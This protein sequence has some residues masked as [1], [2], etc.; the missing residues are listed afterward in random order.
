MQFAKLGRSAM[1]TGVALL[2]LALLLGCGESRPYRPIPPDEPSA[3]W[4]S[5]ADGD[6]VAG[7][8]RLALDAKSGP[9]GL[10]LTVAG[11]TIDTVPGSRYLPRAWRGVW[12]SP[13]VRAARPA[14]LEI[15]RPGVEM[16]LDAVS[17]WVVPDSIPDV[18]L[19]D[20]GRSVWRPRTEEHR[21]HGGAYDFEDGVLPEDSLEWRFDGGAE[22]GARGGSIDLAML[23]EGRHEI[24][25]EARDRRGQVGVASM[26]V[27]LFT[28][29]EPLT[30]EGCVGAL[31][32]SIAAARAAEAESLLAAGFVY[33]P[34]GAVVTW[35]R[36]RFV[37]ALRG[38]LGDPD[39]S[40]FDLVDRIDRVSTW[41]FEG[42][43]RAF[44]ELS[45]PRIAFS[46]GAGQWY[47][48]GEQHGSGTL[49]LGVG[50][51]LTMELDGVRWRIVSW[52]ERAP[53]AGRTL[54][55]VLDQARRGAGVVSSKSPS[56]TTA[57][58]S[59]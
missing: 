19:V 3:Q 15:R 37:R 52:Q 25:L 49:L 38:W 12:R 56:T 57:N 22:P 23:S 40:R 39:L 27:V 13:R 44:A 51:A 42:Q 53:R 14:L 29:L 20:T 30:P 1:G 10:L 28:P 31:V 26:P 59:G 2:P 9:E 43:T 47:G 48:A 46:R 32:Q 4:I 50:A 16:A 54:G 11:A 17:V 21:L 18:R 7:T 45:F 58:C 24:R 6:T 41:T 35:D 55:D 34:C 8:V 5:P 36:Q 33:V